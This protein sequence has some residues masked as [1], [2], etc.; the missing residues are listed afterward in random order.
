MKGNVFNRKSLKMSRYVEKRL[1]TIKNKFSQ[2]ELMKNTVQKELTR[3]RIVLGKRRY[4]FSTLT[5]GKVAMG[6]EAGRFL[7]QTAGCGG[8]PYP[9]CCFLQKQ[10]AS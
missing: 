9:C 3:R 4:Y 7:C 8:I 5:R 10:K 2:K 6:A 1:S